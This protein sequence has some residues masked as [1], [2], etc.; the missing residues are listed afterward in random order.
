MRSKG[1]IFNTWIAQAALLAL[2]VTQ[3]TLV[4]NACTLSMVDISMPYAEAEMSGC[5]GL[6][7]NACL[8]SYLQ[9]DQTPA[10]DKLGIVDFDGA[11]IGVSSS[12]RRVAHSFA[13]VRLPRAPPLVAIPSHILFCRMLR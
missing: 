13:T 9:T 10:P 3:A 8:V 5:G 4:V 1:R 7:K 2:L 12:I 6:S 11:C